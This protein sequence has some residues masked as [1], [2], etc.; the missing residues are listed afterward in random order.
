MEA[1]AFLG[2]APIFA[3]FLT[4]PR[5]RLLVLALGLG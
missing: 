1:A 3:A 5:L 4:S 2:L